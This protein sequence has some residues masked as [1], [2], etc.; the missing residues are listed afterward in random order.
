MTTAVCCGSLRPA[1]LEAQTDSGAHA[2]ILWIHG[3]PYRLRIAIDTSPTRTA[4][5]ILVVVLH[6]DLGGH[7]QDEFAARVAATTPDVI[8]AGLLRPGYVDALGNKSQGSKGLTTGDNY[9]A[10]NTDAIAAA[11]TELKR[12]FHPRRTVLVGHS[13]GAAIVANILGRQP[14]VA[15]AALLVS[16]PCDVP[17]W[18]QHMLDRTHYAGFRGPIEM[19]SPIDLVRGMQAD[20]PVIMV[21]GTQ[22]SVAPPYITDRYQAAAVHAGKHVR[23]VRLEGK[24]HDIFLEPE[25]FAALA[26]LL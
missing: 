23:L 12:R 3:G 6:G 4:D 22:D 1:P 21:V 17:L 9:N 2:Q 19:L 13:G 16:C 18:R 20:V 25:V 24:P 15:D 11:I 5:P 26:R 10:T 14:D 7:E 8:A